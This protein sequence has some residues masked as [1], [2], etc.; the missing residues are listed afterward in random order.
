MITIKQRRFIICWLAI[1]F[2]ALLCNIGPIE[3]ELKE[4]DGKSYFN[5]FANK[6]SSDYGFWPFSNSFSG[7]YYDYESEG[8][9]ATGSLKGFNGIFNGFTYL[10][11]VVYGAVG[12]AIILVPKYWK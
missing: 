3:G 5:L 6:S 11:F 12:F 2:F 4:F 9:T 1:C 8:L 10:E 7:S